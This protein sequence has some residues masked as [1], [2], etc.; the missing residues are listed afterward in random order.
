MAVQSCVSNSST[1]VFKLDAAYNSCFGSDDNDKD[2]DYDWNDFEKNSGGLDSDKDGLS[3]EYEANE[4]CFYAK[5]GWVKGNAAKE[6][7]ILSD[8]KG[9]KDLGI[10]SKFKK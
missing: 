7:E 3:D 1:L 2:S 6:R 10:Y 4:A 9:L 5:M 8:F